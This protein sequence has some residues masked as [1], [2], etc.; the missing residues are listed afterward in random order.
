[1]SS[2]H[3]PSVPPTYADLMIA[4]A[5]DAGDIAKVEYWIRVKRDVD[6]A[7]PLGPRQKALL[8]QLLTGNEPTRATA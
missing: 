3:V 6:Q 2:R 8:K 4:A 1:M 5:E 7:P